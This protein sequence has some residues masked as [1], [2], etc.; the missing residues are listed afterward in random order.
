MSPLLSQWTGAQAGDHGG[1]RAAVLMWCHS[2]EGMGSDLQGGAGMA[3]GHQSFPL[4]LSSGQ[5][6]LLM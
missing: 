5:V 2:P 4:K 3:L 1:G 6:S